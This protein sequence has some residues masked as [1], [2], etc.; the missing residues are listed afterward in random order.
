[1]SGVTVAF[2]VFFILTAIMVLGRGFV[3]VIS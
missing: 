2:W 3:A 1:M